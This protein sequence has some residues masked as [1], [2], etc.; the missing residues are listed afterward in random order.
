VA[1]DV[2]GEAGVSGSVAFTA[3]QGSDPIEGVFDDVEV[4]LSIDKQTP[5]SSSLTATVVTGSVATSDA[6]MQSTMV[7]SAWFASKEF[8]RGT[9]ESS[10]FSKLDDTTYAVTG[11]LTIKGTT[12]TIEFELLLEDS[13]GRGEFTIN[14][15]DY[16]IGDSGQ[17]D[18]AAPEV[19]I[20]FEVQDGA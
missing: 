18:F 13:V 16:D 3:F 15:S 19:E 14:R 17:N 1:S 4:T 20:R 5:E 10:A 7:S 2:D 9:F 8:P 6:Q 11:D 12:Q